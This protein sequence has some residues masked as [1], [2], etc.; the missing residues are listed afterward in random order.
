MVDAEFLPLQN[1]LD[2]LSRKLH[3]EGILALVQ[4][5]KSFTHFF[6]SAFVRDKTVLQLL[7]VIIHHGEIK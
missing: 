6:V 1:L 4:S 5:L 2:A 7:E 3:T